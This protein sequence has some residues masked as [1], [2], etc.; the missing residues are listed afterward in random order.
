MKKPLLRT[1]ERQDPAMNRRT[2]LQ[3]AGI[4][5]LTLKGELPGSA[6]RIEPNG[7]LRVG[8]IGS[9]GHTGY[10][11]NSLSRIANAR[12]VA[13]AKS[14]PEDDADWI[15]RRPAFTSETRV[16]DD[17]RELFENEELDVVG[18][19]MPFYQNAAAS[20]EAARRGIHVVSEKPAATT[21]EDLDRLT[22][23]V[24]KSGIRY[25]LML[26]MRTNRAFRAAREAVEQGMIGEPV[27][28]YSR[29]SYKFGP[30]RP[31]YYRERET[32]G[33]T[34]PWVGIHALDSMR[35][36]S[37]QDYV[38]VA[39]HH[40]NKTLDRYPGCEDY[41]SVLFELSNG[42]SAVCHLDYLR[43]E[44][45]P[46]HGDDQLRLAGTE[47]VVEVIETGERAVL[48]TRSGEP[49]DLELPSR[50]DFFETFV[51]ELRGRG[52]HL[53]GSD[54]ALQI[55]RVCLRA[56]EA[57]DSGKWIEI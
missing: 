28:L 34:I 5:G 20:M 9:D 25:S 21:L 52:T 41:A 6:R 15:R 3:A 16:Y 47:G 14:R 27:L 1:T 48:V 30:S 7:L 26:S 42:G 46:T 18:V 55:T 22:D 40:G 32:Y 51:D 33:G 38:R 53:V 29:K 23:L 13:F 57:A 37:G 12:L 35:W 50:I 24:K 44:T 39:A 2:F 17:F 8:L 43:P 49:R 45:A 36:A 19:C 54:E 56:R 31:W 4:A 11:L 10:V